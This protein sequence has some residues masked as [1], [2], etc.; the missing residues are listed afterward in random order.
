MKDFINIFIVRIAYTMR[1]GSA[2]ETLTR[3]QWRRSK[4]PD[5]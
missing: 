2:R 3:D 5:H 4:R 1:D